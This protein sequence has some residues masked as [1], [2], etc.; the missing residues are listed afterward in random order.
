MFEFGC[1]KYSSTDIF[2]VKYSIPETLWITIQCP[3]RGK[4][5]TISSISLFIQKS[6]GG[7]E[8]YNNGRFQSQAEQKAHW[9]LKQK[10]SIERSLKKSL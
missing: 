1:C 9:R 3:E 10:S 2:P 7:G 8:D 5:P 6:R 4:T